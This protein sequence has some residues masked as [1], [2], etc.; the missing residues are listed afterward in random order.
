MLSEGLQAYSPSI[1]RNTGFP[2]V[3]PWAL[4]RK[5][6]L[7]YKTLLSSQRD[8]TCEQSPHNSFFQGGE[9]MFQR[10]LS[11]GCAPR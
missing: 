11:D 8:N 6:L 7:T 10:A 2:E 4:A 1:T 9:N 3:P 5:E